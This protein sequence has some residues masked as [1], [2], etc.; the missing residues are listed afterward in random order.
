MNLEEEIEKLLEKHPDPRK[1]A[2]GK[3]EFDMKRDRAM[4]R[5]AMGTVCDVRDPAHR[6]RIRVQCDSVAP[7]M[8]TP[9]IPVIGPWKGER[10][11]WWLLPEPGVRAVVLFIGNSR[12]NA[13][14]AGF[15]YDGNHRPPK[16]DTENPSK[17]FI[18]QC[19]N[20]RLEMT[21]ERGKETF[22]TS[23]LKGK[24]RLVTDKEGILELVN[25]LGD[26]RIE[27]RKLVI[28]AEEMGIEAKK[29]LKI[30]CGGE[31]KIKGKRIKLEGRTGV[32]TGGKQLA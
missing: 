9:W 18:W 32:T 22:V 17:T 15:I 8:V 3:A 27:C 19:K 13:V 23:A 21:A 10:S 1:G 7:G 30:K 4:A 12:E 29:S 16:C 31:M 28:E 6:G 26:I 11:G 5:P 24:M 2:A 25:E 20:H 14:V